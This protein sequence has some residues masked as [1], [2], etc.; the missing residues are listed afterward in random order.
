MPDEKEH[1]A[2]LAQHKTLTQS[3]SYRVHDKLIETDRGRGAVSKLV[4]LKSS[5]IHQPQDDLNHA[6]AAPQLWKRE[7]I[8]QLKE[9]F[10]EDLKTGAI[11]E[12]NVKEK[13]ST[14]TLLEERPLKAVV[15]KLCR[16]REEHMANCEPPS[17]VQSP[18]AKVKRYLNSA[19]PAA[20]QSSITHIS[21]TVSAESS[22]FWKKFTEEQANHLFKLTKDLIKANAIKKEVVW[23]RVKADQR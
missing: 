4:A 12:A 14:A 16:L 18:E 8:E 13:L 2:A 1:L 15:I 23:Q 19:Q 10:K 22:R 3:R 11:E 7:E 6:K 21:P 20:A 17:D 5:N 9:L